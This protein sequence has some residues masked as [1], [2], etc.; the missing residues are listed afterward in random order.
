M[1][2]ESFVKRKLICRRSGRVWWSR[3]LATDWTGVVVPP[4]WLWRLSCLAHLASRPHLAGAWLGVK[5]WVLRWQVGGDSCG[6]FSTVPPATNL[7]LTFSVGCFS[8]NMLIASLALVER[9][10]FSD[11]RWGWFRWKV[12]N[13]SLLRPPTSFTHILSW[14]LRL[15]DQIWNHKFS[16]NLNLFVTHF[17]LYL[18]LSF[19]DNLA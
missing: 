16:M 12:F 13:R 1:V 10:G 17:L 9:N 2:L 19:C 14:L 6:R 15:K 3:G 5:K 11:G 8:W 4:L 18:K 7:F